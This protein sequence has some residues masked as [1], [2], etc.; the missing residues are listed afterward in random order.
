MAAYAK[1]P[2]HAANRLAP[3]DVQCAWLHEAGFVNV[4]VPF[5]WYEIAVFGGNRPA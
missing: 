3:L 5:R 2:D 1:R 4:V